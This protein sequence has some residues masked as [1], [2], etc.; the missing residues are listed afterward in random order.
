MY[1]VIAVYQEAARTDKQIAATAA[2]ITQNRERAFRR[3]VT[4]IASEL[5]SDLGVNDAVDIYLALVLP[6]LY[7]TLVIER[8]WSAE[9]YEQ[10]LGRALGDELL[11]RAS[12]L[13]GNA[14]NELTRSVLPARQPRAA[15]SHDH[16]SGCAV[17]GWAVFCCS[18][19]FGK[20]RA[21]SS[22]SS[23]VERQL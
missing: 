22:R 10:W 7:R 12:T 13:R 3:H 18:K 5:R 16:R 17:R 9:R 8:G 19:V 1:D 21:C 20:P 11:G 14:D 15:L 2:T 6:E 4:A 23:A